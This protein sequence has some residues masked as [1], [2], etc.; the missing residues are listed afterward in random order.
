VGG[1]ASGFQSTALLRCA[2]VTTPHERKRAMA[3]QAALE[4]HERSVRPSPKDGPTKASVS[5]RRSMCTS[6]AYPPHLI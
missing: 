4:S 3:R 6:I 2:L 1:G 5:D